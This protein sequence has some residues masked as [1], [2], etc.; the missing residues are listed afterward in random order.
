MAES[1]DRNRIPGATMKSRNLLATAAVVAAL[2]TSQVVHA[3]PTSFHAPLNAMFAK[4]KI[5]KLSLRNGSAAS[6]EV[7]VGENLMTLTAGQSVSLN[8][9]VGTRI[10][11]NSD[12][13]TVK[14]GTLI[15]EVSKELSGAILTLK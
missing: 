14:A 2:L 12:T 13:P 6:V 7:K 9:P 10:V 1:F 15:T 4:E 3:A 8:L 11:A 5:V